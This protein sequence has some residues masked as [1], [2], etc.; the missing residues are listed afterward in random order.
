MSKRLEDMTEPE[1]RELMNHVA[2]SVL[3]AAKESELEGTPRFALILF[4]DPKLGQYVAN[5]TRETMV[6]ALREAANRIEGKEDVTR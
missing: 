6:E 1:I 2:R 3:K 4:N 5:C